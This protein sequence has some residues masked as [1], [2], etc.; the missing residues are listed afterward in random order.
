MSHGVLQDL[1]ANAVIDAGFCNRLLNGERRRVLLEF[2]LTEDERQ[3]VLGIEAVSLKDFAIQL[4]EWLEAREE[5]TGSL[6]MSGG[7]LTQPTAAP[8]VLLNAQ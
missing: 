2:D 1:V 5:P 6:W 8:Q 7:Q 4:D 3:A